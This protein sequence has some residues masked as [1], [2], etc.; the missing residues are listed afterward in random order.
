MKRFVSK[1]GTFL[2]VCSSV[3]L[4]QQT[5]RLSL[6]D[7]IALA[8]RNNLDVVSAQKEIDA[9]EGRIL[10]A[11][12]IPN[13]ELGVAWNESPKV[14][15]FGGANERDISLSQQI[16]F[17]SKRSNR[18]DVAS[19]DKELAQLNW[20]RAKSLVTAR[21][22]QSYYGLLLS[23][24]NV[25]GLEEQLKLLKDFQQLLTVRY[26]SGENNYLDVLRAKVEI[27][28][29]NNDIADARRERRVRSHQLN[30]TIGRNAEETF[31]LAD[32]LSHTP[33]SFMQDSLLESLTRS[34]STLKIAQR[35][36]I[37]QQQSLSL[38]RTSYLPDFEI[39]LANQRRADVNN[40]WGVELK[41][42][43]PLWFWQDPKGQVQ[44]ATALS[45]IATATQSA[46]ERR[47]RASI[48][49]AL[50]LLQVA[51]TQ[52]KAFDES[53]LMDA[54]GI[55]STAITRYQNNQLDVLNLLD[56]YRTYR[57][58]NVEYLRALYNYTVA[59][60]ELEAA[61]ELPTEE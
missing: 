3:S 23:E 20:E 45:D 33:W 31:A 9:T 29:I 38:A 8:H 61:A 12:R 35:S 17:P 51:E 53:L 49:N 19:L 1:T 30:T 16:E 5:E 21:V 43:V 40:L 58:T 6:S 36:V 26:Q 28:R 44:E 39:R 13:P 24:K 22:K 27:T 4:T 46:V 11:G 41:M 37:R 7:A 14:F 15:N 52:L 10:Q 50:D 42:S 2:L 60:A 47:V 54:N 56:V 18:I 34:S 55:L 57:A 32:S 48:L 25:E 59:V